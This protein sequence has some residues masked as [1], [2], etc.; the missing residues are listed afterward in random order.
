MALSAPRARGAQRI[1]FYPLGPMLKAKISLTSFLALRLAA[2]C[3]AIS[4]KG[5]M[6][7]RV[8]ARSTYL[9][10]ILIW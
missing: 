1:F 10:L 3:M 9:F 5:L 2:S 4:Q 6:Y 7:I 8:L